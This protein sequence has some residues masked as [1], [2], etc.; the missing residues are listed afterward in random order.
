[1]KYIKTYE[2][3]KEVRQLSLFPD[4]KTDRVQ[5][6]AKKFVQKYKP[7]QKKNFEN[8]FKTTDE[9]IEYYDNERI[10]N[11]S[12]NDLFNETDMIDL[13][14]YDYAA[15][16]YFENNKD[17]LIDYLKDTGDWSEYFDDIE[18][19][20][21]RINKAEEYISHRIDFDDIIKSEIITDEEEFLRYIQKG[22]SNDFDYCKV[23]DDQY[24]NIIIYILRYESDDNKIPIYRSIMIPKTVQSLENMEDY[25]GVGVYW[26]YS[27][28]GAIAYGGHHGSVMQELVL[29]SWVKVEN[30]EW[31][32]T[33]ERSIYNLRDEQE[34]YLIQGSSAELFEIYLP[35]KEGNIMKNF[36]PK[37]F[38]ETYGFDSNTIYKIRQSYEVD[39]KDKSTIIFDPPIDITV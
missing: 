7:N 6:V 21:E 24:W 34:V 36:N 23:V 28:N 27:E 20:E 2:K 39:A 22:Y 14:E 10:F 17:V 25:K 18:N 32:I 37:Y 19:E 9:V 30:V 38:E 16:L 11:K 1:M 31:D 26:S 8:K 15:K 12:C 33:F 29:K 35:G 4:Q 13:Y 3:Y 5:D